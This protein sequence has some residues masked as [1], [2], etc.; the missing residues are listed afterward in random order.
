MPQ[1]PQG[2][3]DVQL[4]R[5]EFRSD[6]QPRHET[7][8]RLRYLVEPSR[9]ATKRW[10]CASGQAVQMNVSMTNGVESTIISSPTAATCAR[11]MQVEG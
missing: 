10:W 8:A 7:S 1:H 6:L 2:L 3:I 11:A 9:H 4:L 5:T